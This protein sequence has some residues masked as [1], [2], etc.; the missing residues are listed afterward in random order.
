M[1]H[2]ARQPKVLALRCQACRSALPA[3]SNDLAFR[4]PQCGRAWEIEAGALRERPSLYVVPP[5]P[6]SHQLLYLPYW[7]F[8]VSAKVDVGI[9]HN[10]GASR[11]FPLPLLAPYS[12]I[13]SITSITRG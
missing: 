12:A 3:A 1:A 2:N 4:C 5:K 6:V 13:D 8:S 11:Q 7:S 9:V 10:E